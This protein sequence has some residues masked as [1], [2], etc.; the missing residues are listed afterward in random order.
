M[1]K[2]IEQITDT[3]YK[4]SQIA[5]EGYEVGE[6]AKIWSII[7]IGDSEDITYLEATSRC[8]LEVSEL[9][10]KKFPEL[11]RLQRTA[12]KFRLMAKLLDSKADLLDNL[13]LQDV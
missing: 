7:P 10:D 11:T 3:T 8:V 1:R 5:Q 4:L 13:Y 12:K 9:V 6:I 2:I